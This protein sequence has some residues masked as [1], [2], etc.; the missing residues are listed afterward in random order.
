[1]SKDDNVSCVRAYILVSKNAYDVTLRA[2]D[3]DSFQT[4]SLPRPANLPYTAFAVDL[5]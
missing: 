4:A 1:M 5:R 3:F 2:S